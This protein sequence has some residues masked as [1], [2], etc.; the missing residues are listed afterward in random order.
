METE[1]NVVAFGQSLAKCKSNAR[2]ALW[3]AGTIQ[4][5]V[6]SNT[7]SGKVAF[8]VLSYMLAEQFIYLIHYCIREGSVLCPILYAS[9]VVY[10]FYSLLYYAIFIDEMANETGSALINVLVYADDVAIVSDNAKTCKTGLIS[11]SVLLTKRAS[12][13]QLMPESPKLSSLMTT[14]TTHING[15]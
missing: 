9:G 13:S 8:S 1:I 6:R 15:N 14:V 2:H 12:I 4:M 3:S 7:D 10:L 5:V 11:H